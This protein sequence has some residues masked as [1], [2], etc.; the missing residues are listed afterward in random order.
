MLY[1]GA[2]IQLFHLALRCRVG[3]LAS[4]LEDTG[5]SVRTLSQDQV[6]SKV[7]DALGGHIWE[8]VE[9]ERFK[10]ESRSDRI[11]PSRSANSNSK[12]RGCVE[13]EER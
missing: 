11:F 7:A 10:G 12:L 6:A 4:H 8:Y 9:L 1:A 5:Q 2:M 3:Q 13:A